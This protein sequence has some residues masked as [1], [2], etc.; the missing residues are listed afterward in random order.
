MKKNPSRN[1]GGAAFQKCGP[2]LAVPYAQKLDGFPTVHGRLN[3]AGSR[4]SW[5]AFDL[6][7]AEFQGADVRGAAFRARAVEVVQRVAGYG[8]AGIDRGAVGVHQVEIQGLCPRD[9]GEA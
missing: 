9:V 3:E 5:D 2:A 4:I 6:G 1:P 7:S 8:S